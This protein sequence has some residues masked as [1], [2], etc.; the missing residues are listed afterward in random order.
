M[1]Q[2][3]SE[4][5]VQKNQNFL[6]RHIQGG[7]NSMCI[8]QNLD[9]QLL[10]NHWNCQTF[11]NVHLPSSAANVLKKVKENACYKNVLIFIE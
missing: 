4:L 11:S 3:E 5:P 6:R 10:E 2:A 1:V 8:A 7:Q 9:D